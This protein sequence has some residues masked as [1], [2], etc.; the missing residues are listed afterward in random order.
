MEEQTRHDYWLHFFSPTSLSLGLTFSCSRWVFLCPVRSSFFFYISLSWQWRSLY[1]PQHY[2][3][4]YEVQTRTSGPKERASGSSCS[5]PAAFSPLVMQSVLSLCSPLLLHQLSVQE[6]RANKAPLSHHRHIHKTRYS[7][8][9]VSCLSRATNRIREWSHWIL[10]H[11]L[12][13]LGRWMEF[14][15]LTASCAL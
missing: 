4:K 2:L 5:T 7:G 6:G 10:R 13:W 9:A 3:R 15:C 14:A 12:V 8:R 1:C 11:G